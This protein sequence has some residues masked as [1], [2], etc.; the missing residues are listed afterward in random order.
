MPYHLR[1]SGC[2]WAG[3]GS[4]LWLQAP[5]GL[6]QPLVLRDNRVCACERGRSLGYM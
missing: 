3:G 1:G 2:S 5:S 4:S 6:R